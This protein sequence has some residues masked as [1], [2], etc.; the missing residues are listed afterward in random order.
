MKKTGENQLLKDEI[1]KEKIMPQLEVIR[2]ISVGDLIQKNIITVRSDENLIVAIE[3]LNEFKIRHLPVV[4]EQGDLVGIIS[5]RDLLGLVLNIKPWNSSQQSDIAWSK[6]RVFEVMTKTP[7]AISAETTLFEAGNL[8]LDNKIS[9]LPVVE[10]NRLLG[11]ITES[12][13]V[14]LVSQI[15]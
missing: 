9:C 14:K 4:D 15:T 13:F 3:L 7:E 10:G 8:L 12:D 5:D 6:T 2:K 1:L 11:I